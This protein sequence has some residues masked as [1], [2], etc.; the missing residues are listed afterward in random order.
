[1]TAPGSSG[2]GHDSFFAAANTGITMSDAAAGEDYRSV[3]GC[4][5]GVRH[6][7]SGGQLSTPYVGQRAT[8]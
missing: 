8:A 2:A 4:T 5:A 1:M 7:G 6:I 3:G